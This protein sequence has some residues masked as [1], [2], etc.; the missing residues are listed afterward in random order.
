MAV[1]AGRTGG[2]RSWSS[3]EIS[4]IPRRSSVVMSEPSTALPPARLDETCSCVPD[5]RYGAVVEIR[6]MTTH[7]AEQ[8]ARLYL[9]SAEHHTE[10]APDFYQVP[11][12]E[13]VV[14]H[15]A[16]LVE[17][18]KSETLECFVAELDDAVIGVVEVRLADSP[19]PHSM[20][21][22][23]RSASVD[24]VVDEN[25]RRR[26]I[27]A[28]LMRRAEAWARGHGAENLMLDMLR[29]NEQAAAFYRALGYEDH[30]ALLLKRHIQSS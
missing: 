6:R 24:I 25:H 11:N 7:D 4:L 19:S 14:G 20:L 10:V 15:F 5:C 21:R 1:W 9:Q 2:R 26:G 13:P 8:A 27:G 17:R 29:A 30:G 16:G 23:I 18:S 28:A 3:V 22:P 12:L